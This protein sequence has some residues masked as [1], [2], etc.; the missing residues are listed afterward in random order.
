M[1]F[2]LVR[3]DVGKIRASIALCNIAA[4]SHT[5]TV[6][7]S[8][9]NGYPE[10]DSIAAPVETAMS[11]ATAMA[12][13]DE[14]RTV[15]GVMEGEQDDTRADGGGGGG[16][17][18][19]FYGADC[20]RDAKIKDKVNSAAGR[21]GDTLAS[22]AIAAAARAMESGDS[23]ASFVIGSGENH[24]YWLRSTDNL[25]EI[26]AG[27]LVRSTREMKGNIIKAINNLMCS[28]ETRVALVKG[29]QMPHL[30]QLVHGYT[31]EVTYPACDKR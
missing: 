4:A 11:A 23:R 8:Q 16:G 28:E 1:L 9:N 13:R 25:R 18:D 2:L 22:A 19:A 14:K 26:V 17:G 3:S 31:P 30:F 29:N 7:E 24:E 10:P 27:A 20:E 12:T 6:R 15:E 5:E 21:I